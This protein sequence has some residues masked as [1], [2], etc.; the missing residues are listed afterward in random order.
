M[1]ESNPLADVIEAMWRTIRD[2]VQP[3]YE[4]IAAAFASFGSA[5][6]PPRYKRPLIHN[7]RKPRK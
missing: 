6:E 4:A 3:A 2:A 7:G 5:L 1:P